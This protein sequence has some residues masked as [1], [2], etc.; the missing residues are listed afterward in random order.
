MSKQKMGMG[1]N[2]SHHDTVSDI[3]AGIAE[4]YPSRGMPAWADVLRAGQLSSLAILV[5]EK[6]LNFD[7]ADLNEAVDITLPMDAIVTEQHSFRIDEFVANIDPY[8]FSIAPLP[9]GG[10]LL[11]EKTRGVS[12]ISPEGQQ[13]A[14]IKGTPQA[15]DDGLRLGNLRA[16]LGWLLDIALHPDYENNGWVYLHYGDR[17]GDG[18]NRVNKGLFLPVSMNRLERAR[19]QDGQWVDVETIWSAGPDTYTSMPDSGAGGRIAFDD[20]GHVYLSVGV[21]GGSNYEGIQDL[22]LPYGKIHR[23][24]DDG[25]IPADNPF[26]VELGTDIESTPGQPADAMQTIWT[27]G[28]RS[29]QGL[30]FNHL[31]GELWGSEMGPRGGDEVNLLLPGR[32]YGWPL[33]SKGVDYDGT[34]VEYGNNLGIE[35][36]INGIE[37][38]VV[39]FSPS[40][41]I[42]SFVFYRGNAFPNWQ[43]DI[44]IGSLKAGELYRLEIED[45]QLVHRET[46]IKGLARIRDIEVGY[47]GLIYLLLENQ[48]GGKIVRLVPVK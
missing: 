12:I 22:S 43:D 32:N 42:S 21:K 3:R 17:C 24:N 39:D 34:P 20:Q 18:C 29:P 2:H 7:M 13:S 28:H 37:Q 15:Y 6:R 26:V 46:L 9:D 41:A 4:G 8:P 40:P 33:T 47:D 45:N 31:T 30:E 14:L 23:V 48:A 1:H 44:I 38:P 10:F 35:F 11:T 16:G 27:Y 36:D 19:I 25:S 5:S